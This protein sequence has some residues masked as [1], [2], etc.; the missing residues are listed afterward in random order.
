[1]DDETMERYAQ[2]AKARWGQTGA[3][4]EYA[5]KS[6]DRSAE[7]EAALGAGLMAVFANFGRCKDGD[8]ASADAQN[9]VQRL[10]AYL[11][12]H[13]YTCTPEILR[14]LGQMYAVGGAFTENIDKAG[15]PGTAAFVKQAIDAFCG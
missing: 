8:P 6:R 9:L 12:E 15:G 5:E 3:Y 11:T 2:E 14:S 4:R 10:Q 7:T 1:M 13:Y